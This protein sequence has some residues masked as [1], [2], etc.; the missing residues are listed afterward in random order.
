MLPV[1]SMSGDYVSAPVLVPL[2][3]FSCLHHLFLFLHSGER[4]EWEEPVK[5]NIC[6]LNFMYLTEMQ[7]VTSYQRFL[8]QVQIV[9]YHS[10]VLLWAESRALGENPPQHAHL[11]D[12][13][14]SHMT[15]LGIKPGPHWWAFPTV[16][17][18]SLTLAYEIVWGFQKGQMG[19]FVQT[20]HRNATDYSQ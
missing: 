11:G 4:K 13:I 8:S 2:S 6:S 18:W 19:F 14:S 16:W 7:F 3:S 5:L 17:A 1:S 9:V 20:D 15:K 12:N 10:V